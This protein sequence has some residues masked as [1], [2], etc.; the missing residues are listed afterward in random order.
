MLPYNP[1]LKKG[2]SRQ[3]QDLE[4]ASK[5]FESPCHCFTASNTKIPPI[6]HP[7]SHSKPQASHTFH[8][9]TRFTSCSSYC[10]LH[11]DSTQGQ[12]HNQYGLHSL[13][14]GIVALHRQSRATSP[15]IPQS[16]GSTLPEL[17]S[18]NPK[19][20]QA[21]HLPAPLPSPLNPIECL[22]ASSH[23]YLHPPESLTRGSSAGHTYIHTVGRAVVPL[24]LTERIECIPLHKTK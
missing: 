10:R 6:S 3:R 18:Y 13:S 8:F 4:T 15:T 22:S 5:L 7:Y 1:C 16:P 19:C 17:F 21:S 11:K 2:R 24:P 23:R 20:K 12:L 14:L 9:P